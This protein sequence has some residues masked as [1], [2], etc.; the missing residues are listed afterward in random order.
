M[1]RRLRRLKRD[2][3]ETVR[4]HARRHLVARMGKL[5]GLPQKFGQMVAMRG[6]GESAPEYAQ[7]TDSSDPL[8]LRHITRALRKAWG[9][10]VERYI[11]WIDPQGFGA[12][13][14]QVHRAHL[15]D[16]RT[17]AI[18]VR[19]PGIRAAVFNDL[20]ILGW[21]AGSALGVPHGT[22]LPNY[23]GE[24]IRNLEEELDYRCEA[25][26]QRRFH[27]ATSD[28]PAW[29]V[30]RVV[31]ELSN[32]TVL[33]SEWQTGD[34]LE[35]ITEWPDAKRQDVVN[36]LVRGFLEMLVNHGLV[37]AD[38]HP[39]NYRFLNTDDGVKIVLYDF[40]SVL[41][42]VE[43]QRAA[44]LRLL[45]VATTQSG[46]PYAAMLALGFDAATLDPLR[47]TLPAVSRMLVEPVWK[48]GRDPLEWGKLKE[49]TAASHGDGAAQMWM[50]FP[51]HLLFL[52]RAFNGLR[53]YQ[54]R[55]G[56]RADWAEALQPHLAARAVHDRME[57]E[58][59]QEDSTEN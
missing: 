1:V 17:V 36:T 46:D 53:F 55:L 9:C 41:T 12:S 7:L 51:P 5:R 13:L 29:I 59:W 24:I 40:G 21:V 4:S 32:D 35:Q 47:R 6:D 23:R 20:K 42:I 8:P 18:K 54:D 27:E 49:H 16:G 45:E 50:H 44:L 15:H 37:H 2:E 22:D 56:A 38:P 10:R 48:A 3:A 57:P 19:Y 14:G 43:A 31:D 26:H 39:G 28:M 25:S 52:M 30:P 34:R 33:V 58:E 11:D